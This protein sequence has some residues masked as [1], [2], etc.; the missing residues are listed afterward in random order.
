MKV[1]PFTVRFCTDW[2]WPPS[3]PIHGNPVA[4]LYIETNKLLGA[5]V[6]LNWYDSCI[7]K[8]GK[9]PCIVQKVDCKKK[10]AM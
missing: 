8:Y 2:I 7:K 1:L 6:L 5:F 4:F 10:L 9:N 3:V